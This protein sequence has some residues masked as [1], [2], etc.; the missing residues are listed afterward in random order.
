MAR[1]KSK[2]HVV[3]RVYLEAFTDPTPPPDHPRGAPYTGAV[4][5]VAK[6]L[7]EKP[8]RRAPAKAFRVLNAYALRADAPGQPQLENWLSR[9]EDAYARVWRRIT[10]RAILTAA[11]VE[12]LSLFIATLYMRTPEQMAHWQRQLDKVQH[13]YRQVDRGANGNE[14][15]SDAYWAGAD[16]GAKTLIATTAREMA[17]VLM[18]EGR[19]RLVVHPDVPD[20][21]REALITSDAPVVRTEVHV[22]ELLAMGM[23]GTWLEPDTLPNQRA[24]FFYCPLAPDVAFLACSILRTADASVGAAL[25]AAALGADSPVV[26]EPHA[27]VPYWVAP[28]PGLFTNLNILTRSHA[29]GL[30]VASGPDPFGALRPLV[31][32]AD[33]AARRAAAVPRSAVTVYTEST[34]LQIH[35]TH[36]AHG[37]GRHVL[38]GR[39]SFRTDDAD[40]VRILAGAERLPE[41]TYRAVDGSGGGMRDA[42]VVAVAL[43]AEGETVIENGPEVG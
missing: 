24:A 3:P 33:A 15:H 6:S 26:G 23:P 17:G 27:A 39:L 18:R 32:A 38:N 2:H 42:R 12:V 16:E 37:R 22:D 4:W 25:A 10:A 43:S 29:H 20:E 28:G 13:L 41:V 35:A 30:L 19:W 11:D 5:L 1:K 14:R 7:T 40:A 21:M 34:R 9:V 8:R 31:L 36:L